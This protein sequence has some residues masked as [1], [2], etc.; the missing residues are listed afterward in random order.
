MGAVTGTTA[1][2]A[3]LAILAILGHFGET[4]GNVYG[5]CAIVMVVLFQFSS[6]LSWMILSFSYPLEVLKFSQRAKGM[7]IAQ[8]IGYAFSFLNLYTIPI[9][10]NKISW[11]Y[12]AANAGWNAA[13][14]IVV[15]FFF[16]ETKGRTLEEID[17]VFE[18]SSDEKDDA[19][20]R[21]EEA[22]HGNL[23]VQEEHH[24]RPKNGE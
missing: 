23:A 19:T 22:E 11:R 10:I 6:S 4:G 7:A 12:Y 15:F 3:C 8:S 24:E 21:V 9:A 13:I 1:M 5:I 17:A 18:K 20:P 14:I 16:R 2:T